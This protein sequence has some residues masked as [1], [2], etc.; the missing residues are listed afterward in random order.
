MK[1]NGL[2]FCLLLSDFHSCW[3]G[4]LNIGNNKV[5]FTPKR[6]RKARR[7]EN[8]HHYKARFASNYRI[9]QIQGTLKSLNKIPGDDAKTESK[10]NIALELRKLRT[11]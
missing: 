5:C 8:E 9:K 2:N 3:S 6:C 11:R 7:H 1:M 4:L 10:E